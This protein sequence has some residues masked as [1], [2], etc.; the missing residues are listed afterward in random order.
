MHTSCVTC[1]KWG[2]EGLIYTASQDRTIIVW[3]ISELSD[4]GHGVGNFS[5][6]VI[7][8]L[9][10]H[11]HWVNSLALSNEH[12]LRTGGFDHTV[13]AEGFSS[14][15]ESYEAS[16]KRYG[17]MKKKE[18]LVSGSDDFTMYLWSATDSNKP[19]ARMTGHQQLINSV[20]FSPDGL[21]IASGSFDKSVKIWGRDG[22]FVATLRGHVG[23]VYSV[24]WSAD[25]RMV[26]SGSKDS[27][28]KLWS[29]KTKRLSEDL[30]GHADEVFCID[31]DPSG[32]S[33]ASGGKD[34]VLRIWRGAN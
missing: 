23:S 17:E 3:A 19:L 6:K 14:E 34:R 27:T 5:A 26:L 22:T 20:A 24:V 13:K 4:D 10:N 31:W 28:V 21:Y 30:P 7:R 12:L 18:L 33:A 2:G 29:M 8:Q 1:V 25:S 9:K 15:K 32:G 16:V 11:G